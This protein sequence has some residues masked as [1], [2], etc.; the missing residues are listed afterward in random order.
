MNLAKYQNIFF[1][2][3]G[4]IGMSALARYFKSRDLNVAGYDKTPSAITK[5]LEN[6]GIPVHFTDGVSQISSDFKEI[7]KTLVVYTPA[8][9]VGSEELNY[10]NQNGF[11]V[12]K[13]ARVLAEIA[14]IGKSI[15]VGGTHGKTTTSSLIAHIFN[16]KSH[17][18][19]AFLGGIAKNFETN[20]IAGSSDIVVLEADEFDRSFHFLEPDIALITSMDADHLD[21][22]GTDEKIQEAFSDFAKR[23]KPNGKVVAK[24]GLPLE[25]IKYGLTPKADYSANDITIRDGRYHFTLATKDGQKASITTGLPGR[26]NVE[27]AVGAAAACLEFGL[28]LPQVV[29]GIESFTGV[30]RRFDLRVRN[31][32]HIYIDDYA[33]HPEEISAFLK[34]VREMYPGKKISA[35]FQPH[36]FTRTRDFISGFAESLALADELILLDI[37]PA[38]EEAIPGVTSEWLLSII[39]LANKKLLTKKETLAWVT[40]AQPELLITIGAGDIDRLVEPITAILEA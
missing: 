11:D 16:Q 35:I 6:E 10:F 26:H 4:G 34:S 20:F 5:A 23:I 27:N 9:P 36:L 8:I 31:E 7:E 25:G 3:I 38:R 40:S 29:S 24:Y 1:I 22:Y 28:P 13:R 39:E 30:I 37:Y 18:V 15:A 32:K 14:N 21:V 17:K 19:S 2:G 12:F 33:H